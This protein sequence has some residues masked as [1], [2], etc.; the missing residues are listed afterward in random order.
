[1]S[2]V[3]NFKGSVRRARLMFD[4]AFKRGLV[5]CTYYRADGN[6]DESKCNC[7]NCIE[8]HSGGES[9]RNGGAS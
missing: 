7:R 6:G 4:A 8:V 1:M 9:V 2:L 5:R 3:V